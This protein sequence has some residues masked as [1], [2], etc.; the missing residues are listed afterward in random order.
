MVFSFHFITSVDSKFR[1]I[2]PIES[3]EKW[4]LFRINFFEI[5]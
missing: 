5:C 2:N 3:Y 1:K 4:N